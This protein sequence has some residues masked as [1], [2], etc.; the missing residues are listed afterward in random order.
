MHDEL[1]RAG[2]TVLERGWLSSNNVVL[3]GADG[4]G[5]VLVDTGYWTHADQTV[6]LVRHALRGEP[7]TRVLNT[8]LHSDHCGGNAAV[9]EAFSC[10]IDVPVGEAATV[11]LWAEDAL[12]FHATGQGCPRFTRSGVLQPGAVIK[13]GALHWDVLAAPGHDPKSVALYQPDLRLLV[14]ADALWENGFGVVFPELEGEAAFGEVA[15]TLDMFESL[16]VRWV[17]PGHGAPFADVQGAVERARSRLAWFMEDPA[18]HAVHAAK[19]LIKFRLL[20]R[21]AESLQ[22]FLRWIEDTRYFRLVLE[23]HFP[24][25][26]AGDWIRE[27]IESMHERGALDFDGEFVRNV[28]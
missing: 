25:L 21:Q 11:D 19:V 18:R 27:L 3:R 15:R 6:T 13:A 16:E 28:G 7:L 23:R 1:E 9:S 22:D 12:T 24:E 17:I 2:I 14:S 26:P 20:E 5:A 4:E 10:P 8:H